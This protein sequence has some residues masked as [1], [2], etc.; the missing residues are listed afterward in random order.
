MTLTRSSK[1]LLEW[2]ALPHMGTPRK[3]RTLMRRHSLSCRAVML[4]VFGPP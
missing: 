2:L 3:V 4:A 1:L